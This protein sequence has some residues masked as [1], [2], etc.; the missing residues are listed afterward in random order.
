MPV[1]PGTSDPTGELLQPPLPSRLATLVCVVG[2]LAIEW[3]NFVGYWKAAPEGRRDWLA[4]WLSWVTLHSLLSTLGTPLA[5]LEFGK[6][7]GTS[8]V[9]YLFNR[10]APL[11]DEVALS[12]IRGPVTVVDMY[13]EAPGMDLFF[14]RCHDVVVTALR[15]ARATPP[16]CACIRRD[17]TPS[18]HCCGLW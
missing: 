5:R 3:R 9:M 10:G 18:S 12:P 17:A 7:V 14:V 15:P 8:S 4:R 11:F 16:T 2:W 13:P 6:W 1:L